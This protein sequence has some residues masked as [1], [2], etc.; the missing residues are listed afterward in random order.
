MFTGPR[1]EPDRVSNLFLEGLGPGSDWSPGLVVLVA[2][3]AH[4]G[5][6]GVYVV[7]ANRVGGRVS[8]RSGRATVTLCSGWSKKKVINM[9]RVPPWYG[10]NKK[11]ST[12]QGSSP[13]LVV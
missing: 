8:G 13:G 2:W 6:E 4:A 12:G 3:H 9:A 5:G 11:Y 10:S 1:A 7:H